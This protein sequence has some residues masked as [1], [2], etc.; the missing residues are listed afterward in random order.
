MRP[1]RHSVIQICLS[2]LQPGGEMG[3]PVWRFL[4]KSV[5]CVSYPPQARVAPGARRRSIR[6]MTDRR[7]QPRCPGAGAG[8]W[9]AHAPSALTGQSATSR[10][11]VQACGGKDGQHH[12]AAHDDL[13]PVLR[14]HA[15]GRCWSTAVQ[16]VSG[17]LS[18]RAGAC[19]VQL[20][21]G[22]LAPIK[23]LTPEPAVLEKVF[24]RPIVLAHVSKSEKVQG[25]NC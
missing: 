12:A 3:S 8:R 20:E 19:A 13:C 17:L 4:R 2:G 15:A 6:R 10:R 7:P 16:V 23:A 25:E 21:A 18:G 14:L 24:A 5:C 22:S 9:P 11:R 1:G